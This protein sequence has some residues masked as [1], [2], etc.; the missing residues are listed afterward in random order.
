MVKRGRPPK[1][2]SNGINKVIYH[3]LSEKKANDFAVKRK[4]EK[5]LAVYED[6]YKLAYDAEL[7]WSYKERLKVWFKE[8]GF[9]L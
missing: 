4:E 3:P 9:L 5:L 8:K 2:E 1:I 7:S 6:I